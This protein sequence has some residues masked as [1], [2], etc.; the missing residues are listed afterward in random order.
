MHGCDRTFGVPRDR[1]TEMAQ[2]SAVQWRGGQRRRDQQLMMPFSAR[3]EGRL[4]CSGY[5]PRVR[6]SGH[7][8][9][10]ESG[11]NGGTG[12]GALDPS[13]LLFAFALAKVPMYVNIDV[14]VRLNA[15]SVP[16]L[17]NHVFVDEKS[18]YRAQCSS[19]SFVRPSGQ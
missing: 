12:R 14:A 13:V 1:I 8:C 16:P 4:R 7:E 17:S 2:R 11:V 18:A 9:I 19:A 5:A 10:E 3:I 6:A 15:E